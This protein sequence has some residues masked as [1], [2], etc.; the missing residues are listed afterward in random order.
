MAYFDNWD[1][2]SLFYLSKI[3]AGQLQK[4]EL[5]ENLQQCIHVGIL[6]FFYFTDDEKCC[7]TISFCDE[8]SGKKY[9]DLMEI[10]VLR[11]PVLSDVLC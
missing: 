6:D 8:I 2:R 11:M 1:A 4:G 5:Y 9:T 10:Q 7:C 3:F